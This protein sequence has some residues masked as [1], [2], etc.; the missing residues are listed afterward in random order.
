MRAILFGGGIAL[1]ISLLGTRVAIDVLSKRGYGQEIREDGP[2]THHTKRGT[3]TMGGLVVILATVVGYF[4]ANLLTGGAVSSSAL[5]LLFLFVG[6]GF[7]GFLDDF[8]KIVKQ[9]SLGLRSAAKMIGQTVV[10]LVFGVLRSPVLEDEN[11]RAPASHHISFI[12][13]IGWLCRLGRRPADHLAHGQPAQQRGEPHRRPGRAGHRR[14]TMVFGAYTLINIW[15]N[16]QSCASRGPAPTATRCATRSTWPSSRAA[17]TGA[18]FGFLWWNASPAEI[19]M[20]DTGSLALGGALAG[21]AIL[22]RTELLLIVLGGL[23]VVETAVGDPAGRLLQAAAKGKRL[24]RMAPLQH[25]FELLGW[26]R[27]HRGDPLLDH[28]GPLRRRRPRASSTPIGWRGDRGDSGRRLGRHDCLVTA[29]ARSSPASASP[30][31]PPPTPSRTSAPRWSPLD[32]KDATA[33]GEQAELLGILGA[34]VRLGE[35]TAQTHRTDDVDRPGHLTGLD[36]RRATPRGGRSRAASRCGARSSSPGGCATPDRRRHRGSRSPAPTA[37]PRPSRCSTRSCARRACAASPWQRRP[38]A[39]RGGDGPGAVRRPRRRA[40]QLPAAL[41]RLAERRV[42]GGAQ[43][44]RGPPRLVRRSTGWRLRRRQGPIYRRRAARLRLQ[45]R[46]PGD[47]ATWCATPTS[48]RARARSASPSACPAVGMVGV[49]DDILVDRAFIDERDSSAAELCTL[50]DLPSRPA[51]ARRR[52]RAG[53]GGAGPRPRRPA[54]PRSATGCAAS[55]PTGTGSRSVATVDGVHCTST[56]PRPPTRTPPARLAAGL[57]PGRV[58]RRRSGQGCAFDDLVAG[59]RA[60]GCVASVLLGRD[61]DVIAEALARHAPDVPVIV[62]GDGE[63]SETPHGTCGRG[64]RRGARPPGRHRAAG[65][66]LRLDGHVHRLRRSRRRVRRG[67]AGGCRDRR[68][69]GRG[70]RHR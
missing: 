21:L 15:Q 10:A 48:R 2:T 7:V 59:G 25:H 39:R 28:H 8:I 60:P 43:P 42:R 64:R 26:E 31:S 41:R 32:E 20:G 4:A 46:R 54:R 37:R 14:V 65:P 67:G 3:P 66:G 34:D 12:S 1:L 36:T 62:V 58:G 70:R 47:R 55:G 56:T 22:T 38:P 45:R 57:R 52:Q 35:G 16:N 13:D 51:P 23:F 9:R 18:C 63:T 69:D 50:D 68:A 19:F 53:R 17:I 29:S 27:G 40:L 49:V 33:D 61:R 5:L 24:F 6:L 44:R 30:A 11:H